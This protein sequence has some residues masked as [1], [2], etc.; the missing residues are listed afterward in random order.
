M[1]GK[2]IIDDS[3]AIKSSKKMNKKAKE[4]AKKEL[5]LTTMTLGIEPPIPLL[6]KKLIIFDLNKV[7]IYRQK[8]NGDH[9]SF[10]TRPHTLE[11][12]SEL[13]KR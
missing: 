13:S 3:S 7:L 4:R 2:T 5:L 9:D 1:K 6:P 10:I 8:I 11:F 12:I